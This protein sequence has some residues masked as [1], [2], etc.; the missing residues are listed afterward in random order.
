[1][2]DHPQF[3]AHESVT[4]LHD[5]ASGLNAIIAV[6]S[7]HRGPAAGGCRHWRYAT[8]D[9][10]LADALRLSRGMSLKNAMAGLPMGGGKAVI[11]APAGGKQD[12][13][14]AALGRAIDAMG[15]RYVTAEDVGMTPADMAALG[16][17]TPHVAG[18]PAASG[19]ATGSPSPAT[20][21]GVLA[22]LRAVAAAALG[23]DGLSGVHVALQGVGAVGGR[24]A[25]LLHAEGARLTLADLD[26]ARA[27]T[28][29]HELGAATAGAEEILA[30][31]ADIVAPNALGAVL[32]AR[33]IPALRC[34]AVAGAANN[35]LETPADG[36]RLARRGIL[37]APDF[38]I[39]AGGIIHVTA[40][41]LGDAAPEHIQS[42][43]AA[44]GRRL[45]HVFEAARDERRRPEQVA[46][47]MAL[48][49]IG[50]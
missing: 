21:D 9:A 35:Q 12:G 31:P 22:G 49:L 23:R 48:R 14:I 10:A 46:E 34:A 20:A 15:G 39:N 43:V 24:L 18:L 5:R 36:E 25:R 13:Q 7:T 37:Y 27:D 16:R 4:H 50:R 38:I 19:D 47:A 2:F 42:Q 3:D 40:R 28:L 45:T 26:P 41:Y 8:P 1:M 17:Q 33:T 30:V 6:H 32:N 44:I 11:L 29:A